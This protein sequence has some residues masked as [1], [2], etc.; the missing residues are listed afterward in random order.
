M[1]TWLKTFTPGDACAVIGE[2][3]QAHDGSLGFAHSFIDAIADAGAD[4]VKF[5]TH[6]AAAESSAEEPWRKRFN[7]QDRTR[8]DYWRRMEFSESQWLELKTH[9]DARGLMFLSSP[10]SLEAVELL[11]RI[12]MEAWKIASGEITN[13]PLLDA[14]VATG[15]P[16]IL[17][18]GMSDLDEIGGIVGRLR[19]KGARLA[20]LQ[21]SSIYPCPAEQVGINMVPLYRERFPGIAVGISDHSATIYPGLAAATLG[22]EVIEL[23]AT[24][25][26]AMFGPDAIASVT[27]AELRQLTDGVRFIERMRA[28]PVDKAVVSETVTPLRKLFMKSLTAARDLDAGHLLTAADLDSRKPGHG[29]PVAAIEQVVGRRLTRALAADTF[30]APG[31]I[32]PPLEG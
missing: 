12:G 20:L 11:K 22:A 13:L 14:V 17:S 25:D 5:Q 24:F 16:V 23:H 26:R 4:A 19:A 15:Q 3:A 28:A 30:L 18:T 2:V 6:I 1:S 29:V 21:C 9:A 7:S 31:D 10:F 8:Y 32:D 27:M